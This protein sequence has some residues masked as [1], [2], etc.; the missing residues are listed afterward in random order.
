MKT[1][2]KNA[3]EVGNADLILLSMLNKKEYLSRLAQ[4]FLL[5][6]LAKN[7]LRKQE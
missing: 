2:S 4:G 7:N 1:F 6:E 3:F 5:I